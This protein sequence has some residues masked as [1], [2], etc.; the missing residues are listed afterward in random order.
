MPAPAAR[1]ASRLSATE[2]GI[3]SSLKETA[4]SSSRLNGSSTS[5]VAASREKMDVPP[6]RSI[7]NTARSPSL[8]AAALGRH[9]STTTCRTDPTRPPVLSAFMELRLGIRVRFGASLETALIERRQRRPDP[10]DLDPRLT[11][12]ALGG[13]VEDLT[14]GR[15]LFRPDIDDD[16]TVHTLA[17]CGREAS[18]S[19]H[20]HKRRPTLVMT[21]RGAN[22]E[23]EFAS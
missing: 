9:E 5:P 4:A 16:Q 8:S 13:M 14:R 22:A 23:L 7:R 17:C 10:D 18:A 21:G 2:T 11:A 20:S 15:Y 12:I 6:L 19:A 3:G 1:R